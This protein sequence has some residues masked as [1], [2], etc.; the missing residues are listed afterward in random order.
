MLYIMDIRRIIEQEVMK[1]ISENLDW[2]SD[3]KSDLPDNRILNKKFMVEMSLK[4]Y[5]TLMYG[6]DFI[7]VILTDGR[8]IEITIDGYNLTYSTYDSLTQLVEDQNLSSAV[9]GWDYE[10]NVLDSTKNSF[11]EVVKSYLEEF[12]MVTIP[13]VLD[14]MIRKVIPLDIY[15]IYTASL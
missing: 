3:V 14:D 6:Y 7:N 9:I 12:S 5:L 1:T 15:G 11:D 8:V 10:K 13:K 2:V 4:N